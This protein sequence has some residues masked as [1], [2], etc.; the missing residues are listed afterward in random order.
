MLKIVNMW[1]MKTLWLIVYK[2]TSGNNLDIYGTCDID[3]WQSDPNINRGHLQVMTNQ[4]VEYEEI[5][6][7]SVLR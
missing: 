5:L 4:Y 1:N 6:I 2:I 7:N 3:L